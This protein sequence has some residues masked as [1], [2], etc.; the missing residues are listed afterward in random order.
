[1]GG[2]GVGG[3]R[4]GG[5]GRARA[6]GQQVGR[7]QPIHGVALRMSLGRTHP[8]A[9]DKEGPGGMWRH[10]WPWQVR[11]FRHKDG[12]RKRA[13]L[14]SRPA[15]QQCPT[16]PKLHLCHG[17]AR[18]MACQKAATLG[19][20][21]ACATRSSRAS[22]MPGT[23]ASACPG[24]PASQS[25]CCCRLKAAVS[26]NSRC[27]GPAASTCCGQKHTQQAPPAGHT[28]GGA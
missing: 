4:G 22:R 3:A 14:R 5:P 18:V 17:P 26:S 1:M 6:T 9:K 23:A 11:C 8:G 24:I 20:S 7:L 25:G 19:H 27:Q 28:G 16:P 15:S 13:H 10:V 21:I 2:G 12:R